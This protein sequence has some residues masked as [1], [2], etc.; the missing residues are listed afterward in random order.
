MKFRPDETAL[1]LGILIQIL[2][3]AISGSEANTGQF[4][5][6]TRSEGQANAK[7]KAGSP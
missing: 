2:G 4:N 1:D 3:T 5:N 6:H 7:K